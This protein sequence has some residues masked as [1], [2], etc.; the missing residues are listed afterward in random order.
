[1][2]TLYVVKLFST[3]VK[4]AAPER[5]LAMRN[6][7]KKETIIIPGCKAEVEMY[8]Y[9]YSKRKVLLVHGWAGRGTQLFQIAD[10]EANAID[11]SLAVL[12]P[13]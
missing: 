3:P 7:A 1:M 4:F 10:K 2:A 11:T 6:S 9:G 5:E 12:S 13:F 8:I